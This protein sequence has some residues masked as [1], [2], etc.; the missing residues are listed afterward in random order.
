MKSPLRRGCPSG[1]QPPATSPAVPGACSPPR[2]HPNLLGSRP[3]TGHLLCLPG[4]HPDSAARAVTRRTSSPLTWPVHPHTALLSP[5]P[6]RWPCGSMTC[7]C[8][9]G[10]PS[11]ATCARGALPTRSGFRP[12][13]CRT[14]TS[15]TLR[16]ARG[17][18]AC[19]CAEGHERLNRIVF[20]VGT[21]P[22]PPRML[23]Q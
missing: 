22:T 5:L 20:S 12:R 9:L 4:V 16:P 17:G 18:S 2:P 6:P 7:V 14:F 23:L 13:P 1:V 8:P 3:A 11:P 10:T 15:F 21:E 19:S